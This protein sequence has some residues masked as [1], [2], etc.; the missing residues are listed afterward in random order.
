MALIIT[1]LIVWRDIIGDAYN[2]RPEESVLR[3]LEANVGPQTPEPILKTTMDHGAINHRYVFHGEG[4]TID[5]QDTWA[6]NPEREEDYNK[7]ICAARAWSPTINV[8]QYRL[9]FEDDRYG[10]L[11]KLRWLCQ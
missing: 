9:H 1:D 8:S 7:G 3:W 2:T 11:F 4:W 6:V 5:F 10:V